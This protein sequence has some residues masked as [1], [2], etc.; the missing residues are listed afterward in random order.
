VGLSHVGRPSHRLAVEWLTCCYKKFMNYKREHSRCLYS[1]NIHISSRE[2]FL[3]L[4]I[5]VSL[6]RAE[7]PIFV[8]RVRLLL[9]FQARGL[10]HLV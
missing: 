7:G 3:A 1:V 6:F 8:C 4:Q 9:W 2:R 5:S 10:I